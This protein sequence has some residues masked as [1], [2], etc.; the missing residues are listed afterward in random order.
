MKKQTGKAGAIQRTYYDFIRSL[1]T[2]AGRNFPPATRRCLG[3]ALGGSVFHPGLFAAFAYSDSSGKNRISK[4]VLDYS[5]ALDYF[6]SSS[7]IRNSVYNDFLVEG[8]EDEK[9]GR[10]L[11]RLSAGAHGLY[12]AAALNADNKKIT[13]AILAL[14]DEL[15]RDEINALNALMRIIDDI[16]NA[17]ILSLDYEEFVAKAASRVSRQAILAGVSLSGNKTGTAFRKAGEQLS[18]AYHIWSEASR[19]SRFVNGKSSSIGLFDI[20]PQVLLGHDERLTAAL[21]ECIVDGIGIPDELLN[22]DVL[23][24]LNVRA[25]M[26]YE[27]GLDA[28][29]EQGTMLAAYAGLCRKAI[30]KDAGI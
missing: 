30:M 23:Y 6:H 12:S 15:C 2:D 27:S 11:A 22:A 1:K 29:G 20:L 14:L 4:A 7:Y 25:E 18:I 19:I 24:A 5:M 9:S 17:R 28:L 16:R 10:L 8:Q 21:R 13:G 26:H 3:E